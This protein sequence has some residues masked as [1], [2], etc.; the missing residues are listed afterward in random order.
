MI[1]DS[2]RIRSM[3]AQWVRILSGVGF[4][5]FTSWIGLAQTGSP[6]VSAITP[7][8]AVRHT[9]GMFGAQP[10]ITKNNV[11]TP[12]DDAVTDFEKALA[13]A[14]QNIPFAPFV[15]NATAILA[16]GGNGL[17][18]ARQADCSLWAFN[19]PFSYSA[20]DP[21]GA[22]VSET[23]SYEQLLH[24]EAG[25]TTTPDGFG[26]KCMDPT[27][28]VNASDI[29]YV[30][31]STS[32]VRMAAV[33]G[34]NGQAGGNVLFTFVIQANGTFVSGTQQTLPNTNAPAGLVAADLNGDGNPD[35]VA[36]GF[37][38]TSSQT[39]AMTVLLGKADGTFTVGE[40]YALGANS[41]DSAVIGDFNGDGKLDVVAAVGGE[42]GPASSGA[43]TFLPGNGDG[44]F[45]T[46]VS[47]P[48]A[49]AVE[50]LV[51]GDF[52]GDG[53]LDVA[54]G[55][56]SIFLGDGSGKFQQSSTP[57]FSGAQI[58]LTGSAGLLKLT[59]GDFNKD[60]KLD[61]AGSNGNQIL[62]FLG[63]GDGTFHS[64]NVYASIGNG[65]YLTATDIDGDGNLDIYSGAAH[66]GIFNGDDTTSYEGYAL[67]GRGDGTFVGA[68]QVVNTSFNGM[69]KL[70]EDQNLDFIGLSGQGAAPVLTTYYGKG[71]GT[72]T[73]GGTPL[74]VSTYRYN[75]LQYTM[76]TLDSYVVADLNG[77][78]KP[79]LYYP[80]Q[81]VNTTALPN[82]TAGFVTALGTGDGSFATPTFALA[83]S[84][85]PTGQQQV[86]GN[87]SV[88]G[89]LGTTNQNGK[90]EIFYSYTTGYV[91]NNQAI[92]NLGFATQVS[93]GDGTFAAPA[94]TVVY[95]GTNVTNGLPTVVSLTDLNGDKIPDLITYTDPTQSTAAT[96][97]VMLGKAD[98]TFAAAVNL[99][100]IT[101]PSAVTYASGA[102]VVSIAVGDVNGDGIADVAAVGSVTSNG[103]TSPALGVALGKG[104]GTFNAQSPIVL[105][106]VVGPVLPAIGD[107]NGDGKADIALAGGVNG[108]F[109]GNG[110]GTFQSQTPSTGGS[111][112]L[113]SLALELVSGTTPSAIGGFDLDG[114][115][116]MDLVAGDTF[117]L[118]SAAAVPPPAPVSTATTLKASA[119]SI[120]AGTSVTFTA[121]V[122]PASGTAIPTGTVTFMNGTATLGTGTLNAAATATYSTS[123]LALGTQSI[124]AVYGGDTDFSG[125]TSSAATVT[126]TA[127]TPPS[128][129]IAASPASGSV[130]AGGSAQTTITVTPAGGFDQQVSFACSGLPTG[131]TCTFAP[132]TVTPKGTA[133]ATTTL[134]IAAP[135]ASASVISPQRRSSTIGGE[136]AFAMIGGG[137]LW[138]FG[139][140][141][142]G[143]LRKGLQLGVLLTTAA[144]V[145]CGGGSSSSGSGG[146]GDGG[147]STTPTAQTYS[148]TVTATAGSATQ[149]AKYSLT[150]Q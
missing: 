22:P 145:G 91:S 37:V 96:L 79:D 80:A 44:T 25:L 67:M 74:A 55:T 64:G 60:G 62:I 75:N 135:S 126:V 17:V 73:A 32:G 106:N 149:T 18:M 78:G 56:G 57:F 141:R 88:S 120:T 123:S 132:T 52:N 92:T 103:N 133:A 104:D 90:F 63:A 113:P 14:P 42:N 142:R 147:G 50:N 58:G 130:A 146:D 117:F 144:L 31:T 84:L 3:F 101:N 39:S 124:T 19:V 116:K 128:F 95:S 28:G 54:S 2:F 59:A 48:L 38:G 85:V 77:D 26:G 99:P 129:S 110:N 118:Q 71:D 33:A 68:P 138:A 24:N 137:L 150:V 148:I 97:Q 65:G 143:L 82:T 119:P 70:N 72:F 136:A 125:S 15:G 46:P 94:L 93:N 61:L 45:G 29:L 13:L 111:G 51:A 98:G 122:A 6:G 34:F 53:K 87:V 27:L 30:G 127:A 81:G 89:L 21:Y 112:V 8:V 121:T 114:S 108:I 7:G 109:A 100:V 139:L 36:V 4:L 41:T 23:K 11:A 69:E 47:L 66:A 1:S 5:G 35:I 134:S 131:G 9:R 102:T 43:L 40:T 20:T 16:T 12:A 107:F 86:S 115:G 105:A 140:R 49:A 76:T 83:P 10:G